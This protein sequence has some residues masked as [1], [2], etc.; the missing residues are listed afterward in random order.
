MPYGN[1]QSTGN[2]WIH[3]EA[4]DNVSQ[5]GIDFIDFPL[6]I[7]R[8]SKQSQH[9]QMSMYLFLIHP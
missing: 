3:L 2:A 6:D 1:M 4:H 9:H 7:L 5:K 8:S